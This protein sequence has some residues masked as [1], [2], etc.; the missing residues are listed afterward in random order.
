M[1]VDLHIHSTMSDGTQTPE[2]IVREACAKGLSAIAITDHDTIA[3]VR[4]ALRATE[5]TSLTV[6]PAVE[7]STDYQDTEVHILG[8]YIDLGDNDLAEK[9]RYVQEARL[10]RAEKIVQKLRGLSVNLTLE[11]VLAESDGQSLGRPHV[12]GALVR[13]GVCSH[14]QE[15][16]ERYLKRGRA[17]YVPRYKL[18]PQEAISAIQGARGCAV[19]AH[20]GLGVPDALIYKTADAGLQGIE[21]YHSHHTPSHTRRAKRLADELGL[22]ITGGSDS[23]GPGGTCPVEIGSVPVPDSCARELTRWALVHDAPIPA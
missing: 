3:G 18:T 9:L 12:A 16:F 23:H 11:D 8:Y 15:A 4:P 2:E 1:S 21:V 22:L 13:K 6:I 7:I 20:P 14:P 5:G 17:A 10:I 19:L